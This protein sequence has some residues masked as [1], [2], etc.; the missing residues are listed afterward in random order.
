MTGER[1]YAALPDVPTFAEAG[2]AQYQEKGW[3][4]LLAPSGTPKAIIDK[5]SA[6]MVRIASAPAT[7]QEFEASG[8]VP[9]ASTPQQFADM[10]QRESD[11]LRPVLKAANFRLDA[12]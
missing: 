12:P 4:G 5:L 8:L 6:E 2:L 11:T 9:L 3:L 1:R 7:Q 10:L